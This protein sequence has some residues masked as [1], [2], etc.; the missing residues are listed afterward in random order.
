MNLKYQLLALGS[1]LLLLVL[2]LAQT[3][4]QAG[5]TFAIRKLE[6]SKQGL[7]EDIRNLT[8]EISANRSLAAVSTR[9][10]ALRLATPTD[11]SFV[12]GGESAVAVNIS[13]P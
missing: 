3:N 11:V 6:L 8:W 12:A 2:Y 13:S 1:I 4:N 9:A 5:Q 7:S 10:A